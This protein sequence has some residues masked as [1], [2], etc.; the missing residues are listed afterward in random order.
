M[1]NQEQFLITE[2]VLEGMR[3]YLHEKAQC[4]GLAKV[5]ARAFLDLMG[6]KN[7]PLKEVMMALVGRHRAL[8]GSSIAAFNDMPTDSRETV[9]RLV[10]GQEG[11]GHPEC[12]VILRAL[13]IL[14]AESE[15]YPFTKE[16]ARAMD[17][18][19]TAGLYD[20]F[21]IRCNE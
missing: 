1:K 13:T 2:P 7:P 14:R 12:L 20:E 16:Y 5:Y 19:T 21:L 17:L 11:T 18:F 15:P 3:M 8:V 4:S 6:D 10:E 9:R